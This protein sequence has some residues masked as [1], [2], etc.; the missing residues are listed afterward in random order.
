MLE[1]LIPIPIGNDGFDEHR[2]ARG[3][4]GD[5]RALAPSRMPLLL[6]IATLLLSAALLGLW[7]RL[8]L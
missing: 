1:T 8:P 5:E 3:A 4:R 6:L 7:W 2:A